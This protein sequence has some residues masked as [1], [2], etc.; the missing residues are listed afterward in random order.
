MT[1]LDFTDVMTAIGAEELYLE[2]DHES[3]E[4]FF[5][6]WLVYESG[7]HMNPGSLYGAGGEG[8]M[9]MNM[10]SSR[11]VLQEV[12]ESLAAAVRNV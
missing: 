10:A 1:F 5:R 3:P 8:H 11:L 9:R 6:D 4:H 12:L 7:V 2:R